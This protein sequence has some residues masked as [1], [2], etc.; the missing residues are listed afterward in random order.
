MVSHRAKLRN[1][2][3]TINLYTEK[4]DFYKEKKS[5]INT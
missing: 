4:E 3:N 1:L 2:V 5:S